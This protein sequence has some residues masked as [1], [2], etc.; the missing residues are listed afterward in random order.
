KFN[1]LNMENFVIISACLFLSLFSIFIAF[2]FFQKIKNNQVTIIEQLNQSLVPEIRGL[3]NS[4]IKNFREENSFNLRQ[5]REELGNS[6]KN[7]SEGLSNTLNF[8]R[9]EINNSYRNTAESLSNSLN[10]NQERIN[11]LTTRLTD[12]LDKVKE[13][14]QNRLDF[15]Q[16]ENAKKL[17]EMQKIVDEKL[18][19]TLEDRLAKSF[20]LVSE[21][22]EIVH[23]GLGEMQT[24]AIGVG[25]LKKVLSNVK[26][27]GILGEIQLYSLLDAVL[28]PDQYVKDFSPVENSLA[29]VEYAIK[30]PG[31]NDEGVPVY[32]PVDSKFPLE[33]YNR[34]LCAYEA[35]NIEEAKI[36][37][38]A[39]ENDI[40]NFAK[41]ISKKYINPPITTDFAILFLPTE[42]LY[43]EVARNSY[44]IEEL[45][46]NYKIIIAGPT[47]LGALLNSLQ[48]GFKTLAIQKRSGEIWKVL[49]E[50]KSEFTKFSDLLNKAKQKINQAGKELDVLIGTRTNAINRRLQKLTAVGELENKDINLEEELANHLEVEKEAA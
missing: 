26:P 39:M 14:I 7:I 27:R 5:N 33:S 12:Q 25:D 35:S 46:K 24:L 1:L 43:S 30:L 34:V 37:M 11:I 18:Q 32:L 50:V 36:A 3:I 15:I 2:Y 49:G 19:K 45:Q 28:S 22:L 9:E 31:K 47:T 17:D 42:G 48:M 41:D 4:E 38:K 20:N 6:L 29:V 23:K 13:L 16:Q 21:R 8:N 44:L 10:N 40:K